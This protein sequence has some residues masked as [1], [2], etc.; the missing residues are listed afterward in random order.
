MAG[1]GRSQG[2]TAS[3]VQEGQALL[4]ERDVLRMVDNGRSPVPEGR[5]N[6][7]RPGP[8]LPQHIDFM[9]VSVDRGP[10]VAGLGRSQV[11]SKVELCLLNEEWPKPINIAW[12]KTSKVPT[13]L[14]EAVWGEQS[15]DDRKPKPRV[16]E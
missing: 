12:H 1:A 3:V 16:T 6:M 4:H 15:S 2:R 11:L 14:L 7:S 13:A 5:M 10:A 8:W 9:E